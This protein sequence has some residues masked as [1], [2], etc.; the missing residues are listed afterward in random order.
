MDH[1]LP[2]VH[3]KE[4]K[5]AFGKSLPS[6]TNLFGLISSCLQAAF[7]CLYGSVFYVRP[8]RRLFLGF[9]WLQ[10]IGS[11]VEGTRSNNEGVIGSLSLPSGPTCPIT[12]FHLSSPGTHTL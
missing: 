8:L 12:H 7:F 5:E 4:R 3:A 1:A 6:L 11:Q 2:G 9:F 10:V